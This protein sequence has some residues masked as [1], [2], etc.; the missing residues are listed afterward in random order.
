V[1]LVAHE[2]RESP[3]SAPAAFDARVYALSPGNVEFLRR[4]KAWQS[5]PAGRVAPVHAMRIFGD[6]G[7]SR[8]EF[9]AYRAG[10]SELAWIVEDSAL[11]DALWAGL[12]VE[13]FAPAQIE[14][15][16]FQDEKAVLKLKDGSSL[17]ARL[18]VGADGANSFVRRAAG[19]D[20]AESDYGQ[21]AVVANFRCEKPHANT[22]FQ[23]FQ[24]EAVLAFLPLPDGQVSMVW[25][26][27]RAEA[28]RVGRLEPQPLCREVEAASRHAL[29]S[30][31]ATSAPRTYPLRRLAAQRLVGPRIALAGDAG[32]VIHP[33]AGQG[34]NLGLQDARA[35]AD[36]LAARAPMRDPGELRLLRRYARSRAEPI[37]AMGSVVDGLHAL[38]NAGNPLAARLRNAGLNLTERVPVLKNV[39]VRQAMR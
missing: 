3:R 30:L 22:A 21:T 33:L 11:Q 26:L 17:A 16:T 28:A 32:H 27:P 7:A 6:D 2:R 9:D 25:S 10:V 38:F 39:L 24:R 4:L 37:L 34:L 36:T 15:L 20:V 35:L 12:D 29:G 14:A 18:V 13:V 8:L 19:I 31:E 5:L 23:W 1:A